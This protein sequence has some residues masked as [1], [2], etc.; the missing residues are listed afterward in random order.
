M[1]Q[2]TVRV[3]ALLE[4]LQARG[5]T[6]GSTLAQALGVDRRTLRRYIAM[7]EDL[8]IPITST[9]GRFGGYQVVPGF[10]L[11]PMMFTDDEALAL[12]VGL[13][14]AR[15]LGLAQTLPAVDIAKSKLERVFPVKLKKRLSA[16]DETVALELARPV[17]PLDQGVLALLSAAAQERRRVPLEYRTPQR[18]DTQRDF[19]P[20][21]LVYRAGRWYTVGWC[22]LRHGLRS[23]RIDRIRAANA[24]DVHFQRPSAFDAL[25]YLKQS[26]ATL[27]RAHSV[28]VLLATDLAT[29]QRELFSA[30]GVLEWVGDGVLLRSQADDL[31]W[32]ARELSR[33]PFDFK[34]RSPTALGAAVVLAGRRL[35]RLGSAR[36]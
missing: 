20:Y 10:K 33:M 22:H 36:I 13:L 25:E 19:N 29:A 9:Q 14:A 15:G 7:L 26:I 2:P 32:F 18:E 17:A 3:L 35:L 24:L 23:F 31:H 8:G 4:L 11:P 27:P 28:E 21:G 12:A 16:V 6:S 34:V 30:F 1:P 5:T